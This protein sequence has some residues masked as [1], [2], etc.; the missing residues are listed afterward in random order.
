[1][2]SIVDESPLTFALRLVDHIECLFEERP[3]LLFRISI[4]LFYFSIFGSRSHA[5]TIIGLLCWLH[6]DYLKL[7]LAELPFFKSSLIAATVILTIWILHTGLYAWVISRDSTGAVSPNLTFGFTGDPLE[8]SFRRYLQYL[9]EQS[10][11][12]LVV[13]YVPDGDLDLAGNTFLS[14]SA[15]AR[16]FEREQTQIRVLNAIFYSRFV[17][18]AHDVE[19]IFTELTES[20]VIQVNQPQVLPKIFLRSKIPQS[21]QVS[22]LADVLLF[23]LIQRLRRRPRTLRQPNKATTSSL[24]SYTSVSDIRSFRMSSMDAFVLNHV[25]SPLKAAYRSAV[26]RVFVADRCFSG[27]T[28]LVHVIEG[29]WNFGTCLLIALQ[30]NEA[31][32]ASTPK[33]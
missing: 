9:V 5:A 22:N 12:P 19:A 7:I 1:M 11:A 24:Q 3:W 17:G 21:L 13:K 32:S 28:S 10:P 2:D 16:E 8:A 25:G 18:Y 30:L 31:S 6:F 23:K 15:L 33:T 26:I 20:R 29:L 27:H 14:P 4:G